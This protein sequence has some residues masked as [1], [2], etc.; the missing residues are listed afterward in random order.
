M[1]T[2]GLVT[3]LE[4]HY[5]S[6]LCFLSYKNTTKNPELLAPD[7][8]PFLGKKKLCFT[9]KNLNGYSIFI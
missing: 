3:V 7:F 1:G 5:L 4:F 8:Y 9:T 6:L 2:V